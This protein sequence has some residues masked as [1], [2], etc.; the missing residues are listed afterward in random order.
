MYRQVLR[1]KR[2]RLP[3][4]HASVLGTAN[5]LATSLLH[6]GRLTEAEELSRDVLAARKRVLGED[7]LATLATATNLSIC[8]ARQGKVAESDALR[9]EVKA[10]K[11]RIARLVG[12]RGDQLPCGAPSS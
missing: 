10:A 5:N 8:L 4:D 9:C 6:A 11:E 7:H 1:T 2:L 3:E 12:I